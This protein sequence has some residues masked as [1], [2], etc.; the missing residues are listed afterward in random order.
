MAALEGG[1]INLTGL[2]GV[3]T[4]RAEKTCILITLLKYN[5]WMNR[6]PL[7]PV[8]NIMKEFKNII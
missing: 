7:N 4:G 6:C 1:K 5:S 2:S 8:M 3:H